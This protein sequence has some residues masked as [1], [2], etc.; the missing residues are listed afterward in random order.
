ME[1]Q[2]YTEHSFTTSVFS[3]DPTKNMA[4]AGGGCVATNNEEIKEKVNLLRNHGVK[5]RGNHDTLGYNFKMSDVSAAILIEQL[6]KIEEILDKRIRNADFYA[7]IFSDL[8]WL[9]TP[10]VKDNTLHS[11]H[12]YVIKV[13]GRERDYVIKKLDEKGVGNGIYYH[14]PIHK[15]K[16]Y[17]DLG[18][19]DSLPVAEKVAEQVLS[20]PVHPNLTQEELEYISEVMHNI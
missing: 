20:L 15:Q 1:K 10:N 16:V 13:I 8:D 7:K 6:K 5:D 4:S 2:Y 19:K 17:L 12:K 3:F 14:K 18:Y 11:F 9:V